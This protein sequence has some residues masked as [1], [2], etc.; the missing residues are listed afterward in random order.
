MAVRLC[1]SGPL[2][3]ATEAAPLFGGEALFIEVER[4]LDGEALF[5]AGERW[6]GGE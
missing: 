5:I 2:V 1:R 3:A 6:F 4:W